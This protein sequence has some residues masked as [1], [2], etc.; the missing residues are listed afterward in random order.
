VASG[1]KLGN[2]LGDKVVS[3]NKVSNRV[4]NKVGNVS[5]KVGNKVGN[6]SDRVGNKVG[7]ISNGV[8]N[9]AG[10][11]SNEVGDKVGNEVRNRVGNKVRD[12]V[13]NKGDSKKVDGEDKPAKVSEE[14]SIN[15]E[16]TNL[17]KT[18]PKPPKARFR[19]KDAIRAKFGPNIEY[20]AS[21][22]IEAGNVSIKE[23]I[24]AKNIN[25]D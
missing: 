2:K 12:R 3:S 18:K 15:K 21:I 20:T 6:I 23:I 1:N 4:G 14:I 22:A 19:V 17:L 25:S 24:M 13:G 7:D 8:G 9:K 11:I 5:D 16:T 10:D